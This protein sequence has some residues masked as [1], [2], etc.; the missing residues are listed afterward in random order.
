MGE[1]KKVAACKVKPYELIGRDKGDKGGKDNDQ[2]E[3]DLEAIDE[4]DYRGSV[5]TVIKLINKMN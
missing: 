1:I 4:N 5:Q 2:E 3:K